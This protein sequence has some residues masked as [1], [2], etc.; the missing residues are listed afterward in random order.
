MN[1]KEIKSEGLS[2]E[3]N[4][5]IPAKDFAEEVNTKLESISKKAKIQGFRPGKAP[6]ALIEKQYK[7]SVMGEALESIIQT[8]TSSLLKEKSIE[9][10]AMP[11]VKIVKFEEDK[12]IVIEIKIETLPEIKI[13]DFSKIKLNKP[14]AEVTD[15]E[16]DKSLEF[17]AG[18]RKDT[19]AITEERTSKE[20]DTLM[21][22]F[23]GRV[24]GVAF[25]GGKGENYPLVLGSKTFIPGFEDQLIGKK[26]G[27]K[28]DV[29]VKFPASYHAKDLADKDSVFEVDVLEIREEKKTEINE[30]FAKA[31][32]EKSLDDLKKR[33]ADKIA[34][35]YTKAAKMK[36][37]RQLLD[38]LSKEY[39]F[40]VPA[41]LLTQE[42]DAIVAQYEEAKK[43]G[44]I[45]PEDAKRSEKDIIAEYKEI[46]LRRVKLGLLLSEVAK[47]ANITVEQQDIN[48]A[49]MEEAR[50]YP[51][52]E[53][54][55]LQ[56]Y[57]Q[58]KDAIEAL[59]A[60]IFED[61]IVD[62]IL[63]QVATTDVKVSVEEL[64]NF[65]EPV[66]KGKKS[67]KKTEGCCGGHDHGDEGC[68][69]GH[70][71][72]GCKEEKPAKKAPAKK[73]AAKK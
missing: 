73:T 55:V 24:N 53:Q 54:M 39:N 26:V 19:S 50:R 51:G 68:C 72:C 16:I 22:N 43:H 37:K 62:H 46:A 2:R 66:A 48:Q 69:G 52:Q 5:T 15:V 13:G 12:D 41:S 35:D 8:T 6:K 11:D 38:V 63:A 27:E 14:V 9:P 58:N 40:E 25:E 71:E 3:Y 36:M 67:S 56:H 31:M 61:K 21:I 17:I 57:L 60:P 65:D 23:L 49:I 47:T 30:E 34:E 44:Q 1:I 42:T 59:R 64:Y 32:G 18:S 29:T 45:S 10:A 7:S 4:V 20:G 28:V 70:G 33:V